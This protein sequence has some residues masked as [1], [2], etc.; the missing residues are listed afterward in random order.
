MV[1]EGEEKCSVVTQTRKGAV[2]RGFDY[3]VV[4]IEFGY[5]RGEHLL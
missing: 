5:L 1:G 3:K 2:P 4:F